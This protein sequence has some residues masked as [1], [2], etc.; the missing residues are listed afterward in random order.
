MVKVVASWL[1]AVSVAAIPVSAM[2]QSTIEQV[3]KSAGNMVEK[4]LKDANLIKDEIPSELLE[5][6]DKPYSMVG[7]RTCAQ[8]KAEI[9]K[10]DTLL[11]P[12]VDAVQSKKGQSATETMLGAAESVVGSLIPGT[13]L[14]RKLSGA[15][16]AEE[17]AKA[18]ILAGS[19]RR[20]YIK[21]HA[22]AKGCRI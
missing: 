14:I 5:I 12:D 11:G 18:A 13:G 4:P 9:G 16:K 7:L 6:M 15:E 1:V 17:K 22:S 19:L 10:F 21:G 2:A 20:A 3:G 8:F